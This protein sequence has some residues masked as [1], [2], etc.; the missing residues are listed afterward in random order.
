[1]ELAKKFVNENLEKG[2]IVGYKSPMASPLFFVGKKDGTSQPCQ[3][4]R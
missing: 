2:Y 4:Y 1:M 3:D